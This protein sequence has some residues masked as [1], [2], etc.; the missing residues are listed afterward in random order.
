[1]GETPDKVVFYDGDC[2]FCNRSVNFVLKNDTTKSIHFAALQ[3][4]FTKRVF[5][6]RNWS[7]PD[8][9]TFYFM[10]NGV[11]NE[12]SKAAFKVLRYFPWYLRW[13]RIFTIVPRSIRDWVYDQ[14]AKRR[15]KISKGYCVMPTPEERRRFIS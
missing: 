14:V 3:S 1:M 9:S 8:L 10:E 4:G 11:L 15:R 7:Q 6:E 13:L 5:E 12:K 2:G